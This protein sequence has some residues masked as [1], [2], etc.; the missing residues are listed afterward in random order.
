MFKSMFKVPDAITLAHRD[1]ESAK[2]ELLMMQARAEHSAKMVEY[3]Q[4][5]VKRLSKYVQNES[6]AVSG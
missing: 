2:R 6:K 5:L 3:Y 4:D 1:L